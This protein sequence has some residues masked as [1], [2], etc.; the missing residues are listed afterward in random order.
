[1]GITSILDKSTYSKNDKIVIDITISD[2][3]N[4]NEYVCLNIIY[5]ETS[6]VCLSHAELYNNDS[7]VQCIID[8]DYFRGY[9]KYTVIIYSL[10]YLKQITFNVVSSEQT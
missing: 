5:S 10:A 4:F 2:E 1:M 8:P 6:S 7:G 9:G 3:I